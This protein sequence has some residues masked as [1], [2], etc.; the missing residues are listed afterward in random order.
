MARPGPAERP[1]GDS[2]TPR[3]SIGR[4]RNPSPA[5]SARPDGVLGA[6]EAMRR[7]E[8]IAFVGC[9]AA[10]W[11]L[12]TRAEQS[13]VPLIGFLNAASPQPFANYVAGFRAGLKETG[14][15]D[16]RNVAI[17]FR[18]AEG[19]YD[20]LPEMAAD[21]VRRKVVVL[22]ATGGAPSITAAK[23]ATTTIP[24]VF[25]IGSDPVQLGFV[26]SLSR[27]GGN[28]TGVNLFVT[29]MESKRLGLL[30]ALIPGVQL[31]AV[32]LN[33]N[34]QNYA[35][36][37]YARQKTDVEEAA[38]AIDQQIH[39]LSASN[40]SEIDAAFATAAELRAGAMLV[41]GDPFFN[42]QR[43]K[44]IALAARHAIPAIY[45]QREHALA[46]GLM[47]Y[48][49]NLSEGYRQAGVYAG[50]ILKGEKPG[51]LPVVQSSKFEFIIN[52]KTAKALG[53]EVPPN[54]SAE[55]DEIIE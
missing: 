42:S 6:G 17:E 7:R 15:V 38:H 55:A 11:P 20:R 1:H 32:L 27:P 26:S 16:G 50:R 23:A 45:E 39:F 49:T 47:S 22:A 54:L 36:Q 29:A 25:T 30:R 35:R 21:L 10:A 41:A 8:F 44:I 37:N 53:I 46:G 18:W 51:D 9:T 19:H 31:I 43:D 34:R 3:R 33:P 28:I 48:G 4:V 5:A 2:S 14:Y 40:E 52:L 24:I 13:T 12:P